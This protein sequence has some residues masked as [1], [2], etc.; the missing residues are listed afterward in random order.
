MIIV[1]KE[2]MMKI[3][4]INP[5]TGEL[6]RTFEPLSQAATL[7]KVRSADRAFHDFKRMPIPQRA[8]QMRAL[9]VLL[10]FEKESLGRLM[11]MEMGKPLKSAIDE[12]AK[13][14]WACR[15]YADNAEAFL[16]DEPVDTGA[17]RAFVRYQPLGAVLAIMPWNFPFWQL[18]RFGAAAVMAGNV[19]LLKHAPSVPRC[20]LEIESLFQRA[21]FPDG[22]L[23]TLLIDVDQVPDI[24]ADSR[25]Q[26][27]TLT[28]S[29][30]AGAAVASIAAKSIKKA[31]LE[32]GGSDP[33]I[34]LPSADL[35]AAISTGIKSRTLNNGQSCIAAKRFIVH[36]QVADEFTRRF[37]AAMEALKIGDPMLDSTDI[38]P[39]AAD[40]LLKSLDDQVRRSVS[41]G[42]RILTGGK[43]MDGPGFFYPPTV[44]VD[45]PAG[46][47]A[48]IEELFGPVAVV[49]RAANLDEA[50]QIA[51][52]TEYALGASIWTTDPKEQNR[53]ALEIEAGSVFVNGMVAS[54]PRL[55][56][57][58]IKSSGYGRELGIHG[59][60]EF[61]NIK[62]VWIR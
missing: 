51:N 29:V 15:Y 1:G 43:A 32:L 46:S 5:A 18:F 2:D 20:A 33:F 39:L 31:V 27:V 48:R 61:V 36:E 37:T 50:I 59:I 14:A 45:A 22:V 60:R 17:G 8:E 52:E 34:V 19:I 25:V 41:A 24:L 4:S 53:C 7:E 6:L 12:A 54:D 40:H 42:A 35:D 30:R 11:T 55:P 9:A 38:G 10:E 26:A 13:C 16:A 44:L 56:F 28:G 57:G 47:P 3:Q 49:V 23:Q 62:T 21:G 58:G